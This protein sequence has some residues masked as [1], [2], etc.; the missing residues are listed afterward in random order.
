MLPYGLVSIFRSAGRRMGPTEEEVRPRCPGL[1]EGDV[2]P[3]RPYWF[4]SV[5]SS[6]Y[7]K[8]KD[9]SYNY[10]IHLKIKRIECS[11]TSIWCYSCTLTQIKFKF[12]FDTRKFS[13]TNVIC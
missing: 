5:V 12:G 4:A 9:M 3:L 10:T 13:Q 8:E 6:G 1:R 2:P 11:T 7:K